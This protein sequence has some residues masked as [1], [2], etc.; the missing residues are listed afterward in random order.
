MKKATAEQV[1]QGPGLRALRRNLDQAM[2]EKGLTQKKL[3]SL[4]GLRVEAVSRFLNGRRGFSAEELFRAAPATTWTPN[5]LL[6]IEPR[7]QETTWNP[8][9]QEPKDLDDVWA[10]HQ[11]R[12]NEIV[13][14]DHNVVCSVTSR[15]VHEKRDKRLFEPQTWTDK[16][17]LILERFGEFARMRRERYL[18]TNEATAPKITSLMLRSDFERLVERRE[19]YQ[20]CTAVEVWECLEHMR[21][22]CVDSRRFRLVLLEENKIDANLRQYIASIDSLAGRRQ[23]RG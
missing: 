6:E 14:F 10:T 13:A 7:H 5:Q 20:D 19:Q 9:F 16:G 1:F 12:R 23:D 8:L 4:L 18:A 11:R 21:D 17:R 22:E 3:A 2:R 15:L